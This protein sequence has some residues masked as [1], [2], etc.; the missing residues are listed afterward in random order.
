LPVALAPDM[1]YDKDGCF[2]GSAIVKD[3]TLWLMYTGNVVKDDG[4]VEQIQN[5][6]YSKDG[7]HFEK[8]A[9]NPVATGRIL[10]KE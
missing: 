6:A 1:P 3:D 4:T 9:E 2:S 8:I 7:I 10:P 5:M